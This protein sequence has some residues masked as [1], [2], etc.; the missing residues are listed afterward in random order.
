VFILTASLL[1]VL[2]LVPLGLLLYG[3]FRT[4]PPGA[5]SIFTTENYVTAFTEGPSVR[6]L[7]NTIVV[8]TVSTAV[9]TAIGVIFAWVI[10]RTN[11]PFRRFFER[12]MI[13]PYFISPLLGALTWSTLCAPETGFLNIALKG[14]LKLNIYSMA[15][16]CW[17]TCLW[18]TPLIFLYASSGFKSMN[19]EIEEASRVCGASTLTT[20]RRITLPLSTPFILSGSLLVFVASCSMFSIPAILWVLHPINAPIRVAMEI[21]SPVR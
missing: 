8:A 3:S 19:P 5:P 7:Y 14:I 1:I 6:S 12:T 16:I 11:T 10:C 9:A 21:P 13:F 4:A 2:V 18:Y 15:G 20:L 17:V